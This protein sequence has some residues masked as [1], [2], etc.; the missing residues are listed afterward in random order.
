[1]SDTELLYLEDL[2]V[3]RKF[4]SGTHAVDAQQIKSF[5]AEF[6]VRPAAVPS[7]RRGSPRQF[8]RR[9]GGQRV[10]HGGHCHAAPRHEWIADRRRHCRAWRRA[11]M[12]APHATRG[13]ASRRKR[14]RR[15][16]TLALAP[17]PRNGDREGRDA[18]SAGRSRAGG[19]D[20]VV[21]PETA[22]LIG[23]IQE[24]PLSAVPS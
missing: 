15:G 21:R 13:R 5:A 8:V 20:E 16:R 19:D 14:D 11:P 10:A 2:H 4:R 3:G 17:G 6:E 22:G 7:E 9:S 1:M 12:A 18:Q 23:G 24:C